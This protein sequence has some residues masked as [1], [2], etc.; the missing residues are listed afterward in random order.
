MPLLVNSVLDHVLS[1][2]ERWVE[3]KQPPALVVASQST[4]GK[5]GRTRLLCPYPQVAKHNGTGSLDEAAN[6]RGVLP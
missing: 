4:N 1:A 3:N 2:L 6:F 5:L